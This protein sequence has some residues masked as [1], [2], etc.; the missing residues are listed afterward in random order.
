MDT[1]QIE[2]T[3]GR[4]HEVPAAEADRFRTGNDGRTLT[5]EEWDETKRREAISPEDLLHLVPEECR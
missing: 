2:G 3:D 5:D 1:V 4:T